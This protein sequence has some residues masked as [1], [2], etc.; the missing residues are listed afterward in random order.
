MRQSKAFRFAKKL[1]QHKEQCW[2]VVSNEGDKRMLR[3]M[4]KSLGS[5][6]IMITTRDKMPKIYNS[7][8]VF[9]YKDF[10]EKI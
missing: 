7:L 2:A 9:D 8:P 5:N 10:D 6:N 4:L 3:A 1:S